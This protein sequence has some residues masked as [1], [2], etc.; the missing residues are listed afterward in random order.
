MSFY[1]ILRLNI[2]KSVVVLDSITLSYFV[3]SC[4]SKNLIITKPI[5]CFQS[6]L[7]HSKLDNLNKQP[8]HFKALGE[9]SK[10]KVDKNAIINELQTQLI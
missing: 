10:K 9:T 5:I 6:N 3:L 7:V 2:L 1:N 8:I 4:L